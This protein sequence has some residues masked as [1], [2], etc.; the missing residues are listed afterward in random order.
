MCVCT[1][2]LFSAE[3]EQKCRLLSS[4]LSELRQSLAAEH[5]HRSHAEDMLRQAHEQLQIQQQ[6][7]SRTGEQVSVQT[8]VDIKTDNSLYTLYM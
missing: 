8:T 3:L 1:L 2:Y 5:Q 7:T 4:E 6:L